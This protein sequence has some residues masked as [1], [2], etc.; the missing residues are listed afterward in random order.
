MGLMDMLEQSK[1]VA[2]AARERAALQSAAARQDA[3]AVLASERGRQF[4]PDVTD[5]FVDVCNA[6][7]AIGKR[8]G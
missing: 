3:V 1:E 4:D 8:H 6:W 2:L 7:P 5:A